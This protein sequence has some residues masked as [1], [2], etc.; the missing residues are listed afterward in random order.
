MPARTESPEGIAMDRTER[1]FVL[2][3]GGMLLWVI[4][5]AFGIGPLF[6]QLPA[7][8]NF[9][10]SGAAFA[11]HEWQYRLAAVASMVV[12]LSGGAVLAFG[13]YELLRRVNRSVALLGLIFFLIDSV[14]SE[15]LRASSFVRLDLFS[16]HSVGFAAAPQAAQLIGTFADELENIGGI[17]FG[18]G[19]SLFFTLFIKSKYLPKSIA[20]LG[21]GAS[22]L[23]SILYLTM[24]VIPE[25]RA[26][27]RP[28]CFVLISAAYVASG[29][30]LIMFG[31]RNRQIASN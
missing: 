5:A 15:F 9:A 12:T 16:L 20:A 14:F 11:A 4:L 21:L 2:F 24:L 31:L 29:L 13:L 18:L 17:Y 8:G 25:Q 10:E 27:L 1:F 23:F 22:A 6:R 19:S 7:D 3:A 28:I 26:T 30:W